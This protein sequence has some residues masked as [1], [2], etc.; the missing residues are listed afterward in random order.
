MS[1]RIREAFKRQNQNLSPHCLPHTEN[2]FIE[3]LYKS[4]Y[5]VIFQPCS[6]D[7][8]KRQKMH[9]PCVAERQPGRR[10]DL[11]PTLSKKAQSLLA[12]CGKQA[13]AV[14]AK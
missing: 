5:E 4:S 10:G 1:D 8:T 3:E 7:G 2:L 11:K 14:S 13:K 6:L 12:L 9:E